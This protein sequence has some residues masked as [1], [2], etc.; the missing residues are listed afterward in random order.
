MSRLA[1]ILLIFGL[2]LR[3]AAQDAPPLQ[4]PLL[5]MNTVSQDEIILYDV[6]NNSYRS[7]SLGAEAHHVW[8]FSADGCRILFTLAEEG[9]AARLWSMKLDGS[10]A[11]EMVTYSELPPERWASRDIC[12]S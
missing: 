9:Q 2:S 8:D 5:A 7:L 6:Q 11:R 1:L 12:D 10:D 3:L 4:A